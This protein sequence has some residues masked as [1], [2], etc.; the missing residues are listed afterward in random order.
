MTTKDFSNCKEKKITPQMM[1]M[2]EKKVELKSH[3]S[4]SVRTITRVGELHS[5]L[6]SLV[7]HEDLYITSLGFI[8]ISLQ[9]NVC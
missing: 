6:F 3:L 2:I 4:R 1:T 5:S 7:A 9:S 8:R